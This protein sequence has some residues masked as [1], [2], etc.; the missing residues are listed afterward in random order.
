M[1]VTPRLQPCGV[2]KVE[3]K[4]EARCK[5]E[6]SSL[7]TVNMSSLELGKSFH[8]SLI[9]SIQRHFFKF[10]SASLQDANG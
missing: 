9:H 5:P 7:C 1:R 3:Q 10:A 8:S 6:N 4:E 2:W